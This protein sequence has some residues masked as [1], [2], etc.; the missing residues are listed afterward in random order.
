MAKKIETPDLIRD[1]I[2]RGI[3][4]EREVLLIKKRLNDHARMRREWDRGAFAG[5]EFER[6]FGVKNE[7]LHNALRALDRAVVYVTEEQ[8]TKG[9]NWLWYKYKSPTGRERKNNPFSSQQLAV[10][11]KANDGERDA[12][13]RLMHCR[14]TLSHFENKGN[15][16]TDWYVPVY[17]LTNEAGEF[18]YYVWGGGIKFI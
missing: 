7:S 14:F 11:T 6:E 12:K 17:C 13:G 18:S 8:A 4:T 1:I 3:I 2:K 9:F 10:L 15:G 16:F 5:T